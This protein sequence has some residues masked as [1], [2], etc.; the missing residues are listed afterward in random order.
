[1]ELVFEALSSTERGYDLLAPKFDFTPYRT[2]DAVLSVAAGRIGPVGDALDLCCG[3]GAAMGWLRPGARRVVGL[4]FS[5]GM[6]DQARRLS[7]DWV[8]EAELSFVRGDALE[9]PF[10]EEFDVVVCF[11]AFGHILAR[12][13]PRLVAEVYR[14]L[15]PGG[16]FVFVT[17][18]PPRP[19]SVRWWRS[20]LFNLAIGFR[21]ALLSPPFVMY[22]LTFLLPRARQLLERSGFGL[23][24]ARDLFPQPQQ[25]LV[26]VTATKV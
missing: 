21:N 2:P 7:R 12:D 26:M 17:S 5:Q 25:D 8:G 15:R 24:V 4:D 16:R 18:E 1:M 3:T 10:G 11:G 9:L 13:E 19:G 23:E 14:V 22:Y 6:L 20:R